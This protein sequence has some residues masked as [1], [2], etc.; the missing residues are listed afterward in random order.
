MAAAEAAT[1]AAAHTSAMAATEATTS[2]M[3]ATTTTAASTATG[4]R[5]RRRGQANGGNSHQRNHCLAQHHQSPSNISLP[6]ELTTGG[7][8]SKESLSAPVSTPRDLD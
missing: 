2:A 4:Q 8:R 1:K 3:A 5:H 7:D 6:A